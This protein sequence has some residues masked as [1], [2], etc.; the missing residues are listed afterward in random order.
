MSS[1][2]KV[3][4]HFTPKSSVNMKALF[5]SILVLKGGESEEKVQGCGPPCRV[6]L[7]EIMKERNVQALECFLPLP[8]F[9]CFS[10]IKE[11]G[12]FPVW[13][14][15]NA[16]SCFLGS[17]TFLSSGFFDCCFFLPVKFRLSGRILLEYLMTEV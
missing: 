7:C 8:S 5:C 4:V 1:S 10:N 14:R 3:Q 9:L 6:L 17:P 13:N 16:D 15:P 12:L 2:L 11:M